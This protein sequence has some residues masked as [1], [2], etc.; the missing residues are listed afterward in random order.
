MWFY[1]LDV[2]GAAVHRQSCD[3]GIFGDAGDGRAVAVGGRGAGAYFQ[4]YWHVY[5]RDHGMQN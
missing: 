3:S 1:Q 5:R 2:N 4:C